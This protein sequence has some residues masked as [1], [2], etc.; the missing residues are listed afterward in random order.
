VTPAGWLLKQHAV[1]VLRINSCVRL[2]GARPRYRGF[3]SKRI[4][5]VK[6][7]PKRW[8][9]YFGDSLLEILAPIYKEFQ[10]WK[11]LLQKEFQAYLIKKYATE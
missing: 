8:G 10:R 2:L 6:T 1:T 11:V 5:K 9:F 4:T 3:H 7:P